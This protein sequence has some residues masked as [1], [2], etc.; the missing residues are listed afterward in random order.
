MD[1]NVIY[2]NRT[3]PVDVR[4]EDFLCPIAHMH[5][6]LE[7]ILVE[8][9]CSELKIDNNKETIKAGDVIVCFPGQVHCCE[10][11]E[12]GIYH[13]FT[14]AAECCYGIT[15]LLNDSVP[16]NN[17]ISL[18]ADDEIVK[19]LYS[20]AEFRGEFRETFQ[21]GAINTAFALILQK[22]SVS[23]RTK[24]NT[25]AL[26]SIISYCTQN[27]TRELTLDDMADD[28]NLSKYY[29]S[30]L[31]NEKLGISFNAYINM[32]RIN[33]SC[34]MLGKTDK[35]IAEIS[36]KSGFGSVRTFNRAFSQI[37]NMTPCDYRK[38]IRGE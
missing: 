1:T 32:L 10:S 37:M 5:R 11:S 30:H 18:G 35:S 26:Q 8:K 16:E 4:T 34:E 28:I 14:I 33:Y 22:M 19:S 12:N 31:L 17:V 24:K 27:F 15:E 9:G 38:N 20:A 7:I 3:R 2:E 25:G 36:D 13:I 23:P 21:A 29:I 6:E